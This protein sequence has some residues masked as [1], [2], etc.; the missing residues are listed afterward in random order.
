VSAAG[1]CEARLPDGGRFPLG[2]RPRV[3]IGLLIAASIVIRLVY[4]MQ[5]SVGPYGAMHLASETD[6]RFFDLWARRIAAGDWLTAEPLHP[7][8]AWHE[9]AAASYFA[10][11]PRAAAALD[12]QARLEGTTASRLLWQR[13]YGG[14]R[15]HQE[16]LYPLLVGLTYQ[17]LRPDVRWVFAWQLLM[18]ILVN[19]LVF[20]LA[21][22]FFGEAAALLAGGL[23]LLCAPLLFYELVLL[24]TTVEVFATLGLVA[25]TEAAFRRD[26]RGLWFALGLAFG[27]S[28]LLKTTFATFAILVA[29]AVVFVGR[30]APGRI[31]SRGGLALAGLALGLLPAAARNLA[32]G[33]PTL[34][35]SSVG[36]VTFICANAADAR[37]ERGFLLSAFAPRILGETGGELVPS[38]V[39]T[40]ETHRDPASFARLL[41]RKVSA[42][43]HG[44]EIPNNVNLYQARVFAS[45]LGLPV[46]FLVV[47]PLGLVGL[48]VALGRHRPRPWPLVAAAIAGIIPLL[49]F[50]TISRFRA[51]LLAVLIPPAAHLAVRM[52]AWARERRPAV[53]ALAVGAVAALAAHAAWPVAP[54]RPL[55]RLTDIAAVHDVYFGPRLTAAAAAGRWSVVAAELREELEGEPPAIRLVGDHGG[56]LSGTAEPEMPGWFARLHGWLADALE[57]TGQ[58]G[59]AREER[60]REERLRRSSAR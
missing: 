51:P 21:R 3:A 39:R 47:G 53:L 46:G 10:G 42:A 35:L 57:K 38:A 54:D 30:R 14:R 6:M 31:L 17:L 22:R 28:I 37:P 49:V 32:V 1:T 29:V 19:V 48:V 23:A 43:L 50:Y 20:V 59:L 18:G 60:L 36:A 40:L 16:P 2:V 27:V 26:R 52:V 9:R 8:H 15:F 4:F 24:R 44:H 7:H 13:W 33:A 11:H 12:K 25:L 56:P 58:P 45:V 34:G 5:A 41:L 55:V